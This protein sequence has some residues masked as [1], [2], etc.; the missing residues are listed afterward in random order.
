[1]QF[2]FSLSAT[3]EKEIRKS[4]DWY[5]EKSDGLG[6]RF[7]AAIDDAIN[8]ISKNPE[9]Y[10]NRKGN[11][12]EF[13]VKTFRYVIVYRVLKKESLISI[14]HIFHTSRNPKYKYKRKSGN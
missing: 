8:S 10:H 4:F 13:V 5:E 6:F 11:S 12:R 2:D 14:L 9:A 7:V 3:A 1:M